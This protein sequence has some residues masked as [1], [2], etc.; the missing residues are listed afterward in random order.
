MKT[1]DL[2]WSIKD[3]DGNEI[4]QAKASKLL[5]NALISEKKGDAVKYFDWAMALS[6]DGVISVDES[7][8]NK[9][10]EIVENSEI[11]AI[12]SKAQYLKYIATVK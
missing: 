8:F 5:A 2:N 9:I 12:L 10:K 1:L 7:D 11:L 3:L 4:A 6:K